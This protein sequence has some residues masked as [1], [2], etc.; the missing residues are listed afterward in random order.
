[1]LRGI[2]DA[3][4]TEDDAKAREEHERCAS[5]AGCGPNSGLGTSPHG[6][7][8]ARGGSPSTGRIDVEAPFVGVA[9]TGIDG[10][11][12]ERKQGG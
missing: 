10:L 6:S 8:D 11:A 5:Y 3:L 2:G 9:S 12:R 4:S 1:M 7:L